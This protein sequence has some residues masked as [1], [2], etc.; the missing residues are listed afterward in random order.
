MLGHYREHVAERAAQGVAPKPL[1]DTEVND[2]VELFIE[3]EIYKI[4]QKKHENG[5]NKK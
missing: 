2:L 3:N 4:Y 5:S 1:S